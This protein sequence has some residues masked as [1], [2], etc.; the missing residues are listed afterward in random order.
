MWRTLFITVRNAVRNV[1]YNAVCNVV[2]NV[3][4]NAVNQLVGG[5]QRR[6]KEARTYRANALRLP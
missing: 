2:R 1:V 3:V 4:R 6:L 5:R